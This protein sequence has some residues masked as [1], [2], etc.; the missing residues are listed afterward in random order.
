[1][2]T[3]S[4]RKNEPKTNPNEP[5]TNPI[6]ANKMPKQTQFKPKQTQPVVSLSNL[7]QRKE[8]P[9]MKINARFKSLANYTGQIEVWRIIRK[10]LSKYLFLIYLG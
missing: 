1:M 2:D 3:W 4:I 8:M 9:R 7:F 10:K 5:K 6:L